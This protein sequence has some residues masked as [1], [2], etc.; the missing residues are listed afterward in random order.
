MRK[1]RAYSTKANCAA[2]L[3]REGLGG[4]TWEYWPAGGGKW[5]ACFNCE[6]QEDVEELQR[7]GWMAVKQIGGPRLDYERAA[8]AAGWGWDDFAEEFRLDDKGEGFESFWKGAAGDWRG[9]CLAMGI[10]P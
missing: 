4:M 10:K 2:A 9:L 7:R 6:L 5:T 1:P 8:K 3:K